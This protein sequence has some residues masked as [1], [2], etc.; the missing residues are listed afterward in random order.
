MT[1]ICPGLIVGPNL[2]TANFT[3]GDMIG[4][5]VK[6]G[7]PEGDGMTIG[8]VDVR[9]VAQAHL[10]C[11][12]RDTANGQRFLLVE[13]RYCMKRAYEL[14][15]D[16]DLNATKFEKT[17]DNKPVTDILG[18]QFSDMPT[19]LKDMK[20]ALLATGYVKLE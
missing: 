13:G 18:V 7:A 9:Q 3:S 19:T 14:M 15:E 2:N 16:K 5:L 11:A 17:C 1:T 6:D 10:E 4:K 8:M 12:K 20:Q